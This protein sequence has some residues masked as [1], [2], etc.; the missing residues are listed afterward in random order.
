MLMQFI[1]PNELLTA[2]PPVIGVLSFRGEVVW[3]KSR[4]RSGIILNALRY[5]VI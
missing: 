2:L 4:F 1:S 5:Y 3:E